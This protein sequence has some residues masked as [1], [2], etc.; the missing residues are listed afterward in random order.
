MLPYIIFDIDGVLLK[1]QE[2]KPKRFARKLKINY[3]L[4]EKT[5]EE[6]F[7]EC[8]I[9][10]KDLKDIISPR[11]TSWGWQGSADEFL[12]AW[13]DE[14][15]QPNEDLLSMIDLLRKSEYKIFIASNQE[16]YRA[17][18]LKERLF[19]LG[20]FQESF[21][22]WEMGVDKSSVTFFEKV[23]NKLNKTPEAICFFDDNPQY[24]EV[25]LKTGINAAVFRGVTDLQQIFRGV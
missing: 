10:R 14:D 12:N 3:A 17:E 16:K 19:A 21:M 22:S 9:G 18:Y 25:A 20:Y 11:L 5:F 23:I 7:F 1:K 13:F 15:F 24:V 6:V 8:S 2:E 4:A